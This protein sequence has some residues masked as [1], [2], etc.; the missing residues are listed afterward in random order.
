MSGVGVL[1]WKKKLC[2]GNLFVQSMGKKRA[3]RDPTLRDVV[4][5]LVYGKRLG[6]VGM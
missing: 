6:E 3:G 5:G 2:G 1:R 4:L